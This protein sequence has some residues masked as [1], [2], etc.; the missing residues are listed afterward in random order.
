MFQKEKINFTKLI[1]YFNQSFFY[2]TN[3]LNKMFPVYKPYLK[4]YKESA[5][6]AIESEWISNHG[7]YVDLAANELKNKIDCENCILM[8]NG[9]AATHCLFLALKY[10]YPNINKIYLPNNVFIAPYN[11]GLTE[12]PKE[13]FEIMKINNE[14]LNIDTDKEYIKSLEKNSAMVVVHNLGNIVNIPRIKRLRPDIII[15]EDNCE[16]IFGKYENNYTGSCKE[17]LA[18]AVSFYGNKTITTG[19]GGAFFT[20]D[21]EVYDYIKN[22]YSHG[23]S[24]ERYIHNYLG[25]NYRMTNLQAAFLYEQIKDI[26]HILSKKKEVFNNYY[27]YLNNLIEKNKIIIPKTEEKTKKS[28]WMF[29]IIL[30][31]KQYKKIE[32]FMREKN[33]DIRPYFYP[34][35]S[36]KHLKNIKNNY[37]TEFNKKIT[38]HGMI[39]PSYPELSEVNIKYICYCLEE[40]L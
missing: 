26:D 18:T 27:K 10:K 29:V 16:G 13:I 3:N 9:T 37:E 11:C 30:T 19:E 31:G 39:L 20:N 33:I 22:I 1:Y 8:N 17:V 23:M 21:K 5:H 6:K 12:Y 40:C 38:N 25:Y 24:E 35:S 14:T 36:H 32:I 34:V 28:L 2:L 4:K 15:I 7:I